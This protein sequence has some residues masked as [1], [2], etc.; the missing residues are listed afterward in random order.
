MK[1]QTSTISI[2]KAT[3]VALFNCNK[4]D[5]KDCEIIKTKKR[6]KQYTDQA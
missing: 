2:F 4:L 6:L 3:N 5:K 1:V